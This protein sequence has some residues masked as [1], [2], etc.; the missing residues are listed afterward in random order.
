MDKKR[1]PNDSTQVK[2]LLQFGDDERFNKKPEHERERNS[3]EHAGQCGSCQCSCFHCSQCSSKTSSSRAESRGRA[4][5]DDLMSRSP[6]ASPSRDAESQ[7]RAEKDDP[8]SWSPRASPSRD[9]ESRRHAE[10]D[11][12]MSWSPRA[13][14]SRDAESQ[15]RAEKDDPMSRSPRASPSRD[16][17]SRGRAEKDD[18]MSW[19]FSK[20]SSGEPERQRRA[21]EDK[22]KSLWTERGDGPSSC[23]Q[24]DDL[25]RLPQCHQ[26]LGPLIFSS[27]D[28]VLIDVEVFRRGA[29]VPKEGKDIWH[30]SFVKMPCSPESFI[31]KSGYTKKVKRWDVISKCLSNLA[32]KTSASAGDVEDVI[33]KCNP[34]YK[35]QWA[36]D[37]LANFLK[38]VPK[39]ENYY[40]ELFPK[41]A[42][43]ALKLPEQVKKAIPLLRSG[44]PAAITL[45][46]VQIACLLANAFFCTFPHRNTTSQK[47]E[48]CGYPSINFS[49]L[50]G[51]WSERKK[52]KLRAIL[53][54]FKVVTDEDTRPNG[55]VTFKR[56]CD[57]DRHHWES[58]REAMPKL[59]VTAQGT[60][61]TEGAGMLQVDFACSWIGGGVLGS[62]LVQEEI[63]FLIHPELIVSRLF[64]EKLSD[65]E[66]LIITGAQQFSIYCGFGDSFEW[67]GPHEETLK[68]DEWRRLQR[69]ILAIDALN[70]KIRDEQ[71]QLHKVKRELNKAYCGFKG[72]GNEPDIATGKWGCGAFNG[73][74]QLKAVIQLMAAA[75]A[76]RGLAFFTFG[77][78]RLRDDLEQIYPLLVKERITVDKLF[79][80][81][82]DFCADGGPH[83]ELFEFIRK[84]IKS[85]SRM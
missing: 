27:T 45:S 10:K 42:Q 50:F 37:A 13:S 17:E 60:I 70:F 76:K 39:S 7:G 82:Q 20:T 43:L 62:G 72:H 80:I 22:D 74:P 84:K 79:R 59:H 51:N 28:V 32:K 54:Y 81:L 53:H 64:T 15:G 18:L 73:D 61:E 3:K 5:K 29:V 26:S 12:L 6:R 36:F 14:P 41:I 16:A 48:Y 58:C 78:H 77:D 71:Y 9:A 44:H 8:R 63:L 65:N 67:A 34:K 30:S 68:K 83:V 33:I 31:M 85:R 69:Q 19:S 21:E 56:R 23:C 57:M 52:E 35:G 46:Q 2:D 55:L 47:A 11:D 24:L 40:H 38:C 66:C 1:N 25:K 49:S 75:K 4:E